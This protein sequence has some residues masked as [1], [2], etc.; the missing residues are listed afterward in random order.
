MVS[1][2]VSNLNNSMNTGFGLDELLTIVR[3]GYVLM[4]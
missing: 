4:S 3:E 2:A 1:K